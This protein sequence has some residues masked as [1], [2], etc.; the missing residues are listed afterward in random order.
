MCMLLPFSS[1]TFHCV[2]I[3]DLC[4]S[5]QRYDYT[6]LQEDMTLPEKMRME[7]KMQLDA[8]RGM[9]Y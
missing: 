5:C 9:I 4:R 7:Q 8:V 1:E 3:S 6:A 2:T